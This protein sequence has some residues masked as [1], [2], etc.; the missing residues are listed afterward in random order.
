MKKQEETQTETQ[1]YSL[2]EIKK[3]NCQ[4][5]III[6]ERSNGKTFAVQ[7]EILKTYLKTGKQGAIIRRWDLDFKRGRGDVMFAGV[8]DAGI[9]N[10]TNWDGVEFK[11]GRWTLYKWDEDLNKKVYD[12]E[13]F[14]YSFALTN[15]EHDKST[16]YPNITTICF[17]EFLTRQEPLPDEFILFMNCL[18]TIIRHR[19]DVKIYMLGNTVN[20]DSIYFKEMG[21]KHIGKMERGDITVYEYGDSG[22]RVAVEYCGTCIK[23][24]KKS[25]KYFAFDNE[26]LQMIT[27]GAWELAIYPRLPFKYKPKDS[28]F[29]FYIEYDEFLLQGEVVKVNKTQF[30]FIHPWTSEIDED[31]DYI[32][33][34]KADPR[35]NWRRRINGGGDKL[36]I[37]IWEYF[38]KDKVYYSSNEVGELVR[39][40]LLFCNNYSIIKS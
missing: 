28:K 9:L 4:Y 22:L 27:N 30:I 24:K 31:K 8:I 39:N 32:Y 34:P 10:H 6:G 18:S 1:Y 2:E 12:N 33:S 13:P 29:K 17:D 7:E 36:D 26:K 40:Y 11:L 25:D 14:C 23:Q 3:R 20:K 19:D 37:K 5:N 16:S 21:L 15:M 35:K 38:K